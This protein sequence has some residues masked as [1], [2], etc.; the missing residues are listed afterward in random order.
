MYSAEEL[1]SSVSEWGG[2]HDVV[3]ELT[4]ES[5]GP[6]QLRV[7]FDSLPE[8]TRNIAHCW[9]MSDTV[10]RDEAYV[11]LSKKLGVSDG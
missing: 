8:Q 9:G 7:L 4:G 3:V 6:K 1:F 10:F 11:F 2:F 5:L